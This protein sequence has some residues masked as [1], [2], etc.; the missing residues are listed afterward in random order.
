MIFEGRRYQVTRG[1]IDFTNPTRIEPFFD[2]EARDERPRPGADLP[3][4]RARGGHDRPAAAAAQLRSA[5]AAGRRAGAA[6]RRRA[7]QQRSAT[8]SCARC[9]IR[10][11][12]RPTFS[13]RAPRSAGQPDLVGGRQ[14]GRADLRRRHVPALA[15]A[16][17]IRIDADHDAVNPSARL[18]IGKRISD[19]AYLTFSRSLSSAINDQIILLEYD[20]SDRLSW[21]LSRNEDSDL[22]ARIPR[23]ARLLMR[24]HVRRC[25][26]PVHVR[27][28]APASR[29]ARR[30]RLPRQAGRVGPAGRSRAGTRTDPLLAQ[31][32][33]TRVGDP[34]SMAQVRE[35]R[36]APVQPRPLRGCSRRRRAGRGAASRCVYELSPAASGAR[37]SRSPAR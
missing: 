9:R 29:T 33:E 34:L 27:R 3:R 28:S 6:L 16:S 25:S 22:R 32:V 31:V 30:R 24:R 17:S 14:G 26:R 2:I 20:E 13:R 1:A 7:A 10:T 35:T 19:R 36:D 23:E 18:T 11:S 21:I 4:H 15:V 37:R 12:A 8:P 5:A